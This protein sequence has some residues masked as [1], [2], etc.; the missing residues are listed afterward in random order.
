[1]TVI[2]VVLLASTTIRSFIRSILIICLIIAT[3]NT[4]LPF[5]EFRG[6]FHH[7]HGM[8]CEIRRY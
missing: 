1:M 6:P 2:A 3:T 8:I 7:G 5:L 4:L